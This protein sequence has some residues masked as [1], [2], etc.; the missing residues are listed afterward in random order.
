M[1]I[2]KFLTSK[3]RIVKKLN[4]GKKIILKG[5]RIRFIESIIEYKKKEGFFQVVKKNSFEFKILY[6]A[7]LA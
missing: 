2:V 6:P 3:E 4:R 1:I 5:K 7:K